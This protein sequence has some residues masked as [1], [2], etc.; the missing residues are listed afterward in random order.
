MENF[1]FNVTSRILAVSHPCIRMEFSSNAGVIRSTITATFP[2]SFVSNEIHL[3]TSARSM[4]THTSTSG[5][6]ATSNITRLPVILKEEL[7][8]ESDHSYTKDSI[9]VRDTG[10]NERAKY[11]HDRTPAR[12]TGQLTNERRQTASNCIVAV[13]SVNWCGILVIRILIVCQF[14]LISLGKEDP[15]EFGYQWT[16]LLPLLSWPF[17]CRPYPATKPEV[18]ALT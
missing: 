7:I 1:F 3:F 12:S 5:K 6:R 11:G 8:R 15:V 14:C 10:S 9:P 18:S 4:N 13:D 17:H 2:T 16:A